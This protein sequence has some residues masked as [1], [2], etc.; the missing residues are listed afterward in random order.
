MEAKD[1]PRMGASVGKVVKNIGL[2][3]GI[4][5]AG[6][7]TG[8][9]AWLA[10]ASVFSAVSAAATVGL[11]GAQYAFSRNGSS[12]SP[13]LAL[14]QA[15]MDQQN[16]ANAAAAAAKTQHPA[17]IK[18][19]IRQSDVPRCFIFGRIKTAGSYFFYETDLVVNKAVSP[20]TFNALNL[21]Q[22]IYICDGPIDGFDAVLCDDEAFTPGST[23]DGRVANSLDGNDNV[24]VPID[25]MKFIRTNFSTVSTTT[26]TPRQEQQ[27]TCD[28]WVNHPMDSWPYYYSSCDAGYSW[29]W[30]TVYDATTTTALVELNI[31]D[32]SCVAFEPAYGSKNGYSS[33]ILNTLMPAY[34][35]PATSGLWG[36]EYLGKG[37]T[38][39]Y[40]FA[41]NNPGGTSNRLKYF[42]N[43]WPEWSTVV[44]GARVY[45]PRMAYQTYIDNQDGSWSLYNVSWKWSE[46]P[47]LIAAHFVSWLIENKMTAITGVDWESIIVAADD[48]DALSKTTK[49]YFGSGQETYEKFARINCVYYF[50]TPPRDFLSNV[51]ASCD[52]T[53]SIDQDGRF[54]MWI[55][56]WEEPAVIFDETDISGFTED[57]VEAASE[58]INEFHITY[59][60]PRQGYQKYEAATYVD[61]ESQEMVGKRISSI[62][63]DMVPSADQ[64]YRLAQRHARRING[65][66]KLNITLGPRGM[67]A[68]KQRVVGIYAPNFGLSG[69]W[70]IES[71]TPDG[72]LRQWQATLREIDKDVFSDDKPPIDPV[73][74][75]KIVS[76][77]SISAPT[78]LIVSTDKDDRQGA[79]VKVT[80]DVNSYDNV[81]GDSYILESGLVQE[82]TLDLDGRYSID[83]AV[84][85]KPFT[86]NL[87]RNT[88]RTPYLPS[89]TVVVAQMRY[90]GLNGQTSAWADPLTITVP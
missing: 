66:K 13:W 32:A 15:Q 63:F 30:V 56:K 31:K 7:V 26:Y 43:A 33:Y 53:Y 80:A 54:T 1:S 36:P 84:T 72:S 65:K 4:A 76:L 8:G 22:G 39:L 73:T 48:C 88:V 52:G 5:A 89:G 38:C 51:M 3:L 70:R 62:S 60:E 10:G 37:I 34:S 83:G 71:L 21:Y 16:A 90:V 42:P 57:F 40:T 45:D 55:G 74:S 18:K 27:Y 29:K 19:T 6:L 25:G 87:S 77:T 47:A 35:S 20:A 2:G 82:Q 24:Y 28:G 11:M 9:A 41:S 46:N 85:W 61:A 79:Y 64:A 67:L 86:I 49:N 50:D 69:T 59:T 23:G 17:P 14:A 75:L 58:A 78:A 44:R 81:G 68:I 12:A